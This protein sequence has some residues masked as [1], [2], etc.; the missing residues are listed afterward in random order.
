MKNNLVKIV[1]KEI[2]QTPLEAINAFKKG[3]P[4][5]A[6]STISYAG[7]LDPMAHGVLILL[8]D[9]EN[10]KRREY[11][12]LE[13]EYFFKILVGVSTDTYDILGLIK[14]NNLNYK[15]NIIEKLQ[16]IL[17]QYTGEIEQELPPYSSYSVQGKPLFKWARDNRLGEIELPKRKVKIKEIEYIDSENINSK[18]LKPL[19]IDRISKVTGNFRQKEIIDMWNEVLN[20]DEEVLVINIRA[21]VS[22]GTYIRGLVHSFSNEFNIPMCCLEIYRKRVD[23]Y[24]ID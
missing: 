24:T 10:K 4:Q 9:G 22:S 21:I 1:Y 5:Y 19:I 8:I 18:K 13:K 7:R 16:T 11:E 6:N 23:A 15:E 2:S 3:N 12:N 17:P 14:D 20:K